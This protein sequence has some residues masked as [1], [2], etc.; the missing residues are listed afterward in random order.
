MD[1]WNE[2]DQLF[3]QLRAANEAWATSADAV[4]RQVESFRPLR[5]Q[6][7]HHF[8]ELAVY[9]AL[10]RL[11]GRVLSD[12]ARI[13]Q[14]RLHFGLVRSALIAWYPLDDPRPQLATAPPEGQYSLEIRVGPRYLLGVERDAG[15]A[16][17]QRL[18]ILIAGEKQMVALLPTS[19]ERFRA[20]LLRAFETPR[21]A[22]PNRESDEEP[23]AEDQASRVESEATEATTEGAAAE[24]A[25]ADAAGTET[26]AETP[27]PAREESE[28][29]EE[30][31]APKRRRSRAKK[32]D[33]EAPPPAPPDS[34]EPI[35][36]PAASSPAG[37]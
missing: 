33:A 19:A 4:Q 15:L 23:G 37:E 7:D 9:E 30:K 17:D 28:E 5:D 20:A 26:V 34:D 31:A 16:S 27:A 14:A 1:E 13:H 21:Y 32:S 29:S 24:A 22:G 3:E 18:S 25:V 10:L 8:E 2:L 36:M 35:P 12:A 6:V 11:G